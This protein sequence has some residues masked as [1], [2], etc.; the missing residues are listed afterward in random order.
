[1]PNGPAIWGGCV[2]PAGGWRA[3][4]RL[5]A[6]VALAKEAGYSFYCI[7]VRSRYNFDRQQGNSHGGQS[8]EKALAQCRGIS[9]LGARNQS[10]YRILIACRGACPGATLITTLSYVQE[11]FAKTVTNNLPILSVLA[12]VIFIFVSLRRFVSVF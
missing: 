4:C 2:P 12:L 10:W 9:C 5:L 6:S 1:M 7:Q 3:F 11:R 8:S